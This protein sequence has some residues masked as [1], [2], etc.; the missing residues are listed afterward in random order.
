ML[1]LMMVLMMACSKSSSVPPPV[2]PPTQPVDVTPTQYGTPFDKVPD[3]ADAIIYQVNMRAF[4]SAGTFKGVQARLDSIKALGVN[5][6]YLLPVY[7]VGTV[8]S[9]NSPYCIK[10]FGAV[11]TE[12]GNLDDLRA[13]VDGAHS[14][15]MSVIFDWVAD[16]TA[17]DHAWTTAHKDWYQQDAA[18][19]IISP[20]N[21]GWNDVAALDYK[22]ASL[23]KA[24]ITAMKYWVY[25]ANIDGYRCDAAD[26]M[27]FDFW[28][29]A[30]D[31]LQKITTHKLL[32]YAEGT[33]KDQFQAGFHLEYGMG[34]Y[35][36]LKDKIFNGGQSVKLIDSVNTVE[37]T[38]ALSSSQVVRYTSNHDVDASDGTPLELFGG[39]QG[40]LA[41]FTVAAL[42]KSVPMIYNGQE[43][44]CTQRLS[45]F[46]NSTNIDW[47]ANPDMTATYKKIIAFRKGSTAVKTGDLQSY[48]SDDVCAFTKIAGAQQVLVVAN[49]R[50]KAVTYTVPTALAHGWNNA[51][52]GSTLTLTTTLT[53]QPFDYLVLRND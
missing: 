30:I 41:V 21:T 5:V 47:T 4:S 52:D 3:P 33:R 26:F 37:Y 28:Q 39:K 18:G 48:S 11:N 27:P 12:F 51:L 42:M 15:G 24:M 44:G 17:W 9:V 45:Y 29:Q 32:L 50:N 36:T 53:L 14:R 13:L 6:I 49:L 46:N 23:R 34:F 20:P 22:S 40:S 7:P 1:T 31:S 43:V 38:G 25:T 2:V 8:K 16:H 19:N 35:Y 10:D